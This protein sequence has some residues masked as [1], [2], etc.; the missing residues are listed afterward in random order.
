MFE[1]VDVRG[2]QKRCEARMAWKILAVGLAI[3]VVRLNGAI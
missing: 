2:G 3:G 1:Q